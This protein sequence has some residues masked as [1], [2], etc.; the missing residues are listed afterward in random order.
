MSS[1]TIHT[2]DLK[3]FPTTRYRGSKRKILPW[4]YD[5]LSGLEYESVLDLFGGTGSVSYM[6]KRM[7]KKVIYNDHL[8]FNHLIGKA[9]IENDNIQFPVEEIAELFSG[10]LETKFISENFSGIYYT[11]S[12][13]QQLDTLLGNIQNIKSGSYTAAVK[14]QDLDRFCEAIRTLQHTAWKKGERSLEGRILLFFLINELITG[15]TNSYTTTEISNGINRVF[16]ENKFQTEKDNVSRYFNFKSHPYFRAHS[17]RSAIKFSLSA[18]GRS[19][20]L[21]LARQPS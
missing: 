3:E 16:T 20:A 6:F 7:G 11:D 15:K 5:N 1:P 8:R 9:L 19:S 13:N 2:I 18:T 4:I 14:K 17:N 12:E 21:H 10:N